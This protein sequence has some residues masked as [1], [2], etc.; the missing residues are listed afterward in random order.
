MVLVWAVVVAVGAACGTIIP[1]LITLI[2]FL[3]VVGLIV[4]LTLLGLLLVLL[5]GVLLM[6]SRVTEWLA[7]RRDSKPGKCYPL[8]CTREGVVVDGD[9]AYAWTDFSTIRLSDDGVL[10]CLKGTGSTESFR[11]QLIWLPFAHLVN[12]TPEQARTWFRESGLVSEGGHRRFWHI[13][14]AVV[15]SLAKAGVE[16][17]LD[18]PAAPE[19]LIREPNESRHQ[20]KL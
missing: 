18:S 8:E 2:P 10:L 17:R 4:M 19:N 11:P 13:R 5:L 3:I 20:A 9:S 12:G 7:A 6:I 16:P 14:S 15:A 1:L